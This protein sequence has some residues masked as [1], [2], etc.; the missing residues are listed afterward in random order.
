MTVLTLVR[1]S[2]VAVKALSTCKLPAVAA[3]A[4]AS[5]AAAAAGALSGNM[6]SSYNNSC[7]DT[8]GT[9]SRAWIA[10]SGRC[11]HDQL[12]H[13]VSSCRTSVAVACARVRDSLVV[14]LHG[15]VRTFRWTREVRALRP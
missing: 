7:G 5:A 6:H 13:M 1:Y 2:K 8:A 3:A 4:V 15:L 11:L 14:L 12:P 10:S 9:P